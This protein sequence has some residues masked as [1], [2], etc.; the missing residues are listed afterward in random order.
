MLERLAT[1]KENCDPTGHKGWPR[2][3]TPTTG[4]RM[5]RDDHDV[6]ASSRGPLHRGHRQWINMPAALATADR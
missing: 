3:A 1:T 2:V 6:A 4:R 5:E